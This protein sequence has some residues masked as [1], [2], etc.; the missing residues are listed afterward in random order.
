MPPGA[1]AANT[2]ERIAML[3]RPGNAPPDDVADH[4]SVPAAA[5]RQL[6]APK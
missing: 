4:K 1:W 3:L 6:P 5:L 2:R